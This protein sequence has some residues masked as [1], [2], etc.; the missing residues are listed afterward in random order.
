MQTYIFLYK[1]T[2]IK[3]DF[4]KLADL[5]NRKLILIASTICLDELTP[6]NKSQFENIYHTE[7]F[8]IANLLKLIGHYLTTAAG[9][10][11]HFLTN[12]ESCILICAKLR[13]QHQLNG[14][15]TKDIEHFS[16]KILMKRKLFNSTIRIPKHVLF[17]KNLYQRDNISYLKNLIATIG[18]PMI[19]KPI[20]G[21]GSLSTEKITNNAELIK[22]AEIASK[23]NTIFEIDEYISG[24]LFHCDGIIKNGKLLL[25]SAGK[26]NAP[27]LNFAKGSPLGTLFITE[28]DPIKQRLLHFTQ[29]IVN[30]L[31]PP[32]GGIHL[33]VFQTPADELVF[34]EIAARM[35]GSFVIPAYEKMTSI[36]MEEWY[37]KV[38]MELPLP[39]IQK[40]TNITYT[41]WMT[42][43]LKTGTVVKLVKPSLKSDYTIDYHVAVNQHIQPSTSILQNQSAA[44]INFN[45]TDYEQLKQDFYSLCT[46]EPVI[47][48]KTIN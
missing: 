12:D 4:S 31:L 38:Q 2:K 13:E 34:L 21:L 35:P 29:Q 9:N 30:I 16:N 18:Y 19:G 15:Y 45:N 33:E 11:V 22:F 8:S 41:S 46:F 24:T 48:A 40:K 6:S 47:L 36:N 14:P 17:D 42:F 20:D 32:D 43:P 39:V 7:D 26:Y 23:S 3:S 1:I 25:F 27:C 10:T 28:D 5:A 37:F 44:V